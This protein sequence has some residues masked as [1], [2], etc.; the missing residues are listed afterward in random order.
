M[1]MHLNAW[2]MSG[3]LAVATV[4][5]A[6]SPPSQPPQS[7]RPT[8]AVRPTVRGSEGLVT[9][10]GCLVRAANVEGRNS[11]IPEGAGVIGDFVL[12]R[13]KVIKGTPPATL[14]GM[15]DVDNIEA[16]LLESYAGQRVQIDGWFDE[17]DRA[18]SPAGKGGAHGD[19]VEIRGS[20]IRPI[21][22]DCG[23]AD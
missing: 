13:A 15:Y 12:T 5:S 2:L 19:L 21:A 8:S 3:A 11:K 22:K 17:L 7:P 14:S 6:Q 20:A 18:T 16:G 10:E 1:S 23:A 4:A 9:L